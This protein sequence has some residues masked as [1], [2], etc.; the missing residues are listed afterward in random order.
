MSR[1]RLADRIRYSFDNLTS[2]GPAAMILM[3][4]G[5]AVILILAVT[6]FVT[7][8]NCA[9]EGMGSIRIAWNG[10]MR[11]LDAGTMGG[12]EGSV[13]FLGAMLA[14]TVGGIFVVGTL[15]GIITNG[16]DAKLEQ[17]RKGR[18][19]VAETGHT[20]IL[21][22]SPMIFTIISELVEANANQKHACV[23]ILAEKDKV[24]MEDEIRSKVPVTKTTRVVCRTGSPIEMG[25]LEIVNHR[26]ARSVIIL[27]PEGEDPDS[28]VIKTVLAL[29]NNPARRPEPY[30]IVGMLHSEDNMKVVEM[31]GGDEVQLVLAGDLIARISAQTCRQSGL[32]L[33]YTELLDF[34][35]DEIYITDVPSM[36]GR[37]F[38]DVLHAFEDSSVIGIRKADGGTFLNPPMDTLM[39]PGDCVIAVSE[40]DDT[41]KPSGLSKPPVQ[42]DLIRD[43]S[44]P[45]VGPERTLILGFN[46]RVP[47]LIRELDG[48]VGAGS[49][50]HLMAEF[51][52]GD[53]LSGMVDGQYANLTV[54]IAEG[55]TTDRALLD[56][57]E[58]EKCSHVILQSYSDRMSPQNAD[59]KTLI[60]LLHLR[61]IRER[62]KL[63]FSIVSEMMDDR[64]RELAEVTQ[65]DDFIV[66]DKLI[67]LTLTQISENRALKGVFADLFDPEGSEIYLKPVENYVTTGVPMTF[68]TV[69]ESARRAGEVALGYR[70]A[71]RAQDPAAAHGVV[72]NPIKS[73]QVTF[74]PGDR[75]VVLAEN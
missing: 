43:A 8:T 31:I 19:F 11:T 38:G 56:S 71:S 70:I 24:E 64:N 16:I 3:L 36:V 40:D 20:V 65:A 46:S 7:T 22:W 55:S 53:N 21:G 66:S 15:I 41:V 9:P 6:A 69:V 26:G 33:I 57:L 60:T 17:M 52:D 27:P 72:V 29:V 67:S 34:G 68:Y 25:D 48:Y 59:A 28:G 47:I 5:M 50:V 12:D 13:P 2:R 14:V 30:H 62:K 73:E 35:G 51:A 44:Q 58:L 75:I 63:G 32:S 4:F 54:T 74:R 1:I 42:A 49:T 37:S 18:S 10:L 23:A 61:N 45:P 39:K